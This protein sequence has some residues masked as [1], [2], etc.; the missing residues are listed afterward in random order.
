MRLAHVIVLD[1]IFPK[2]VFIPL[3]IIFAATCLLLAGCA[4]EEVTAPDNDGDDNGPDDPVCSLTNPCVE[5]VAPDV[6]DF[7]YY[8]PRFDFSWE[9]GPEHMIA[10]TRYLIVELEPGE[11]GTD[12]LNEH[13][14]RFDDLWTE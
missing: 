2:Y 12:L 10:Y 9:Q 6:G 13:P 11:A 1:D 4:E 14:E 7:P 3:F 5:I 8:P